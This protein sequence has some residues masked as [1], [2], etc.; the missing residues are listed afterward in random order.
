MSLHFT[1]YL[2]SY[3]MIVISEFI[4][5]FILYLINDDGINKWY[6]IIPPI[7]LF[8]LDLFLLTPITLFIFISFLI[9][10]PLVNKNKKWDDNTIVG[11]IGRYLNVAI[12]FLIPVSAMYVYI[13]FNFEYAIR[14]IDN[15]DLLFVAIWIAGAVVITGLAKLLITRRRN[16]F[17]EAMIGPGISIIACIFGYLTGASQG[18]SWIATGSSPK[19][20]YIYQFDYFMIIWAIISLII[21]LIIFILFYISNKDNI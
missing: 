16:I 12:P 13:A 6:F 3:I 5:I 4:I 20:L 21:T 8:I 2:A 18:S 15:F 14:I 10:K 1:L 9:G 19:Y 7:G 11:K 17:G